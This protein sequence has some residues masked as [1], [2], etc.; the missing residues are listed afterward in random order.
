MPGNAGAQVSQFGEMK[1][2]A[3]KNFAPW[4]GFAVFLLEV[5]VLL[6]IGAILFERRDA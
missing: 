5:A 1:H 4:T 3:D 6:V 2:N